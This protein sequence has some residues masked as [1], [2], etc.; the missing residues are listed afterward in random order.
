MAELTETLLLAVLS[1][2]LPF[3]VTRWDRGR[4]TPSA[5][6]RAWRRVSWVS[7][8]VFFGPFCLPAHF[9]ITRRSLK[10]AL[11]GVAWMTTVLA[12]EAGIGWLL[13]TVI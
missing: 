13:T 1:I 4:L 9:W 11:L 10:G 7:A 3:G 6:A 8:L 12:L 5:Q 2:A